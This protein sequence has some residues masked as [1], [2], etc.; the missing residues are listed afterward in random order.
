M[1]KV[2]FIPVMLCLSFSISAGI[3]DRFV[4]AITKNCDLSR[5]EINNYLKPTNTS[6]LLAFNS[7]LRPTIKLSKSCKI[8][9]IKESGNVIGN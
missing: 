4:D 7:C 5:E 6:S 2:F 9:C 3:K 8:I 1:T